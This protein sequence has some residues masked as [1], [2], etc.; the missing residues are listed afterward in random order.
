M[1]RLTN[2]IFPGLVVVVASYNA[3][4]ATKP[5]F[6]K[7]TL[8]LDTLPGPHFNI[9]ETAYVVMINIAASLFLRIY[10]FID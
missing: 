9:P 8:A 3:A 1:L 2:I 6:H 10:S 4:G 5:I 7:L